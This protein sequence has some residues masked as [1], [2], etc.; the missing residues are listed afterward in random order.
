MI[1]IPTDKIERQQAIEWFL[2]ARQ[3]GQFTV[4]DGDDLLAQLRLAGD[5]VNLERVSYALATR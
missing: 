5:V 1:V 3:R 2:D 4:F